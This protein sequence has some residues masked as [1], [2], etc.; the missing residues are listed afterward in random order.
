MRRKKPTIEQLLREAD[1]LEKSVIENHRALLQTLA[2]DFVS[3]KQAAFYLGG[4]THQAV[5]DR[6]TRGTLTAV[7]FEGRRYISRAQLPLASERLL[8]GAPVV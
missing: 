3:P 7:T 1:T 4:I 8:Q 2:A 5:N 6:I